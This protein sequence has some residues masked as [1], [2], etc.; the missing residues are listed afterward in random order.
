LATMQSNQVPLTPKLQIP[1]KTI[2]YSTMSH[3]L[4]NVG[5]VLTGKRLLVNA[6]AFARLRKYACYKSIEPLFVAVTSVGKWSIKH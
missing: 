2:S 6:E 5:L 1:I 3:D 4:G